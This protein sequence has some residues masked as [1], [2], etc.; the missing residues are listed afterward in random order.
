MWPWCW[1]QYS[2]IQYTHRNPHKPPFDPLWSV[3]AR[4]FLRRLQIQVSSQQDSDRLLIS[5]RWS[6]VHQQC[7]RC[8]AWTSFI[9]WKFSSRGL[10]SDENRS[11]NSSRAFSRSA[12]PHYLSP[13]MEMISI[14]FAL[15]TGATWTNTMVTTAS[16]TSMKTIFPTDVSSATPTCLPSSSSKTISSI[17]QIEFREVAF[18]LQRPPS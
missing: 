10:S 5:E 16:P 8:D 2:V 17:Y 12:L 13:T 6:S 7:S 14:A 4:Q 1:H 11:T 15:I 9:I 18:A 3:R